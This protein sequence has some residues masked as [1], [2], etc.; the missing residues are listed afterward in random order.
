MKMDNL[1]R[2]LG[3]EGDLA[4]SSGFAASVMEHVRREAAVP[5]PISFPWKRALPG[6]IAAAV[7]LVWCVVE[8]LEA[9][10]VD[11]GAPIVIS[12]EPH[13]KMASSLEGLGWLAVAVGVSLL[14]WLLSR[15]LIGRG[16]LV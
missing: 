9:W 14:S 10:V 12:L 11:P 6:M 7:G 2:I 13:S 16:G 4:P 5:Q 3:S 15:R 8:L 1:D